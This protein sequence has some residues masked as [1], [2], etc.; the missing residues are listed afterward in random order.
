[1][2]KTA[3][4]EKRFS[5]AMT[6]TNLKIYGCITMFF[7]TMGKALIENGLLHMG[8]YTSEAELSQALRSSPD[9]MLLSG[10]ALVFRLIGALSIPVFAFLLAEGFTHTGSFPRY[11]GRMALFALISEVPYDFAMSR[12][13]W[14]LKDQNLLCTLTLCLI[15]LYGLDLL[16]DK[17]GAVCRV[18]QGTIVAAALLWAQF[19]GCQFGLCVVLLCAVYYL[20]YDHKSLRVLLGCGASSLYVTAP[21]S[22][23]ALW[24][25]TG[26]RGRDLNKYIFYALYPAHLLVLGLIARLMAA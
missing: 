19:F 24:N 17:K 3:K 18:A 26:E 16:R 9:L 14:N 1:M 11:L 21:L 8:Q 10:W 4:K 15:M 7:T 20:A 22:G 13:F 6:G 12:T 2:E 25:Y 5:I 23:W